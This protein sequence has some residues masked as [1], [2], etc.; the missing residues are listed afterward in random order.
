M[1][2]MQRSAESGLSRNPGNITDTLSL[3]LRRTGLGVSLESSGNIQIFSEELFLLSM[4]SKD[5]AVTS[6]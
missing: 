6:F 2:Y 5:P 1:A 4:D 3:S